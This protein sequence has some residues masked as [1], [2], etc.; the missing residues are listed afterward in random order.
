[1]Y[2]AEI[3]KHISLRDLVSVIEIAR[4]VEIVEDNR[5]C[6]SPAEQFIVNTVN[7]HARHGLTPD[8]VDLA[9][10]GKTLN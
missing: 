5:G 1:M 9:T 10:F 3:V 7:Y 4:F 8:D 6:H 2:S